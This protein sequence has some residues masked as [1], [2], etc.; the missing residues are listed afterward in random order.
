MRSDKIPYDFGLADGDIETVLR[1]LEVFEEWFD[2]G[3]KV[4]FIDRKC[5]NNEAF[6]MWH[7][8]VKYSAVLDMAIERLGEVHQELD[9]ASKEESAA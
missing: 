5:E 2:E 4:D 8:S 6:N 1:L 3:F 7:D 9:K